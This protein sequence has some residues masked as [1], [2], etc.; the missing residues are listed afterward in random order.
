MARPRISRSPR[1]WLVATYTISP[2]VLRIQSALSQNLSAGN[3]EPGTTRVSAA[4]WRPSAARS[5]AGGATPVLMMVI[6]PLPTLDQLLAG[7]YSPNNSCTSRM[8]GLRTQC[9][10]CPGH[11]CMTQVRL[12]TSS[13]VKDRWGQLAAG[14]IGAR[15]YQHSA[16]K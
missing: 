9:W 4:L 3:S 5:H 1:P 6:S 14:S 10:S 2:A 13:W 7:P 8:A 12:C 11:C 16:T 15:I